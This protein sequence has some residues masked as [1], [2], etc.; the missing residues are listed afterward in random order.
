M[1][2]KLTSAEANRA[3]VAGMLTGVV[4]KQA[5]DL[6]KVLP[7]VRNVTLGSVL[8]L[9][10]PLGIGAHV[11]GKKRRAID[12]KERQRRRQIDYLTQLTRAIEDEMTGGV[13]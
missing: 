11:I 12:D 8:G 5:L 13:R 10:I 4:E 9:G 7:V 2:A 3:L 1:T 6:G